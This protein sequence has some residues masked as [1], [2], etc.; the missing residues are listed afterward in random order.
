MVVV[1][2]QQNEEKWRSETSGKKIWRKHH[3]LQV[4]GTVERWRQQ[5][6]TKSNK[7]PTIP[8]SLLTMT[9]CTIAHW[10]IV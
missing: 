10:A 9:N 1:V 7:K 6:Q 3:A 8:L 5:H 4:T 2:K